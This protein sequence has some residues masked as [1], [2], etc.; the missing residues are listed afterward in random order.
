MSQIEPPPNKVA[1]F[2]SEWKN[3]LY[4]LW[5]SQ[6]DQESRIA[7]LEA[8]SGG[9]SAGLAWI[10]SVDLVAASTGTYEYIGIPDTTNRIRLVIHGVSSTASEIPNLGIGDSTGYAAVGRVATNYSATTIHRTNG[11]VALHSG[12]A[13]A[14]DIFY[15]WVEFTRLR[16]P[17]STTEYWEVNGMTHESA[18]EVNSIAGY[19]NNSTEAVDRIKLTLATGTFDSN[20][21]V[22]LYHD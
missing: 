22:A 9:G 17:G 1:Q 16:D 20:S 2:A 21:T 10:E 19:I 15:G 13:A 5:N 6:A 4:N 11:T 14:S 18:A 8:A 12:T 3:W 7:A